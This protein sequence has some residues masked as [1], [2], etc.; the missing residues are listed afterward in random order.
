M[1]AVG[2]A[3]LMLLVYCIKTQIYPPAFSV[4]GK[5]N[6]TH[7]IIEKFLKEHGPLSAAR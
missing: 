4:F 1:V 6:P 2:V 3:V 5:E 7:Q